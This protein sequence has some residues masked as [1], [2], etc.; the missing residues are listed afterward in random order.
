MQ[1]KWVKSHQKGE[2]QASILNEEADKCADRQHKEM[3]QQRSRPHM[4]MQPLQKVQVL[5]EGYQYD[6]DLA[7]QASRHYHGSK[8]EHYIQ[9]K[10]KMTAT[11][12]REVDLNGIKK[13]NELLT[14]QGRDTRS[15]FVY[16]WT[17]NS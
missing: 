8:A 3:G 6:R 13:S 2:D 5:F 4:M 16:R 14:R 15:K 10:M 9:R 7:K 17:H 12:M 11:A 1:L